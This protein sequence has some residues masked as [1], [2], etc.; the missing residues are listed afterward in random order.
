MG[1][2]GL[3]NVE[4]DSLRTSHEGIFAIGDVAA[5][6]TLTDLPIPR[7]GV[8]AE[9]QGKV[10]ASQ[11]AAELLGTEPLTFEGRGHCFLEVGRGE[12]FRIDGH[13]L[14]P[15]GPSFQASEE[16]SSAMFEEKQVFESSR[17][18]SWFGPHRLRGEPFLKPRSS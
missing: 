11:I 13:F 14:G 15:K 1:D 2:A 9:A 16:P 10:V 6:M 18:Q 7:A 5:V 12:A 17:I 3:I 4:R 8:L